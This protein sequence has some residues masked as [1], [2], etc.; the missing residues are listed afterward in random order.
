MEGWGAR[1]HSPGLVVAHVR[2]C[3]L[4]VVRGQSSR[5]WSS[6]FVCIAS[7]FVCIASLFVCIPSLFVCVPSLFMCVRFRSWACIVVRGRSFPLVGM[8]PRPWAFIFVH[9]RS[10]S[11]VCG[12]L[13]L[14]LCVLVLWCTVGRLVDPRGPSWCSRVVAGGVWWL[15]VCRL[16]LWVM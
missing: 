7:L 8:H 4:G 14:C 16:S 5:A 12:Q 13:C 10:F 3:V 15:V 9:G 1:A 11:F 6:S 2:S